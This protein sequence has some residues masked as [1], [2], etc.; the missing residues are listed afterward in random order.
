MSDI[1]PF[2]IRQL[3]RVEYEPTYAAMQA[4][5]SQR[6]LQPSPDVPDQLW[7]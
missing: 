6:A 2:D 1:P 4:F 3:G 5:T 7:I